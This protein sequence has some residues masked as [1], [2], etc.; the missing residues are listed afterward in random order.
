M[1]KQFA[2]SIDTEI[3][4]KFREACDKRDLKMN[5]VIEAFMSEFSKDKFKVT[6]GKNTLS[7]SLEEE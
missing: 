1:R 7:L 4:D 3:A 5:I 6:V 2:T